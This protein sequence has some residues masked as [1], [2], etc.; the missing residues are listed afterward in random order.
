MNTKYIVY[1]LLRPFA[2]LKVSHPSKKTYDWWIPLC[3]TVLTTLVLYFWGEHSEV[4]SGK[5]NL[6]VS[7]V[8]FI[9]N[10]PGFYIAA[11]AAVATFNRS[12]M[13]L[14][15]PSPTPEIKTLIRGND[16]T[17]KLTR[18]RYLCLLF[19][20]LTGE[21]ICLV[22]FTKFA[23]VVVLNNNVEFWSWFGVF[24]F[25]LFFWQLMT[26]TLYGLFYMGDKMHEP[27]VN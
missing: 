27:P 14:R 12:D 7:L 19:A 22:V 2:Y 11:L 23:G 13:D 5:E 8:S 26:A 4:Y 17:I 18:R 6:I 25:F 3:L 16:Q 20:F 10:L 21:S 1:Q 15:L 24:A 9:A